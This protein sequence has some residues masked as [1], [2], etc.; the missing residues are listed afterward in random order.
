VSREDKPIVGDDEAVYRLRYF[1]PRPDPLPIPDTNIFDEP[2]VGFCMNSKWASHVLGVLE[3]LDQPDAWIGTDEE[4]FLARQQISELAVKLGMDCDM[5]CDEEIAQLTALVELNTTMVTH[6]TTII[7]NQTTL[8]TNSET[9]ITQ[10]IEQ[11]YTDAT[12]I[13]NNQVTNNSNV[14]NLNQMLYNG[15]PQSISPDLGENFNSHSEG[16]DKLCAAVGTYIEKVVN[17][18]TTRCNLAATAF[19]ITAAGAA[20]L[21]TIV[22][23]GAGLP[24]AAVAW[25]FLSTTAVTVAAALWNAIA[26]DS[27]AKR[28]VKCCMYDSL[29]DQAITLANFQNAVLDCG[30]DP[31]TFEGKIA[32]LIQDESNDSNYLA[33]LRALGQATGGHASDCDCSCEDAIEL[34]DFA[35][36]GCIITPL[37][38]CIF[39]I[40]QDTANQQFGEPEDY[41]HASAADTLGRCIQFNIVEGYPP[42]SDDGN[43]TITDCCDVEHAAPGGFG[44][45]DIKKVIW[46][47]KQADRPAINS[48][49]Q[50]TLATTEPDCD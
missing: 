19:S 2:L 40:E 29:K 17:D 44:A 23:G 45:V 50:V 38:N 9:N 11:M 43:A 24:A 14:S 5:C 16:D 48:V 42:N 27:G 6:L 8:I 4:I 20:A 3:A 33:F 39:R 15:T 13:Y 32:G 36:T 47:H 30:F 7:S 21:F 22:T 12:N 10:N 28:K 49:Y 34:Y 46:S 18:Y 26:A 1:V 25:G 35:E 37:G 31:S 41:Y